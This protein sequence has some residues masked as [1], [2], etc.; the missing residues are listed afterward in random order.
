MEFMKSCFKMEPVERLTCDQLLEH[1]YLERRMDFSD[2]E[3]HTR[4]RRREGREKPQS[5]SN[6]Y[7]LPSL[8]G[9]PPMTQSPAPAIQ[10]YN[11]NHAA[12]KQSKQH[13]KDRGSE[14]PYLP[15]I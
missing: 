1:A 13:S 8:T 2:T 9:M 5:R 10:S 3:R 15:N 6:N 12:Q 14:G 4:H 11:K 7:N